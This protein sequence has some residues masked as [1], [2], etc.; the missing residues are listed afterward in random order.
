VEAKRNHNIE[1]LHFQWIARAVVNL[2]KQIKH[3]HGRTQVKTLTATPQQ[4]WALLG[5]R[6]CSVA[7]TPGLEKHQAAD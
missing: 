1:T 2:V 6:C 3:T 5:Y 7:R 4:D